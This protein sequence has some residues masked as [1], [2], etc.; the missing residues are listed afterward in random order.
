MPVLGIH[1]CESSEGRFVEL[2]WS[3]SPGVRATVK[4]APVL[5]RFDLEDVRW[6][7]EDYCKAWRVSSNPVVNRIQRAERT[8]VAHV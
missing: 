8:S 4:F 6:Y 7:H 1:H 2:S 5:G 3:D